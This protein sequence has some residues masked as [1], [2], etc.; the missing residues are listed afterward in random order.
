MIIEGVVLSIIVGYIRKGR[1]AN[2]EH[3]EVRG[4]Y[5]ILLSQMFQIVAIRLNGKVIQLDQQVFYIMH[6]MSYVFLFVPLFMNYKMLSM[7]LLG[8]GTVFNFIPVALNGG[9]MPVFLPEGVNAT[10]DLGHVLGNVQTK[11]YLLADII[12][13]LRPYPLPKVISIGDI[14]LLVGAFLF[15]QYGMEKKKGVVNLQISD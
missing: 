6:F 12:P 1:L 7:K 14:F 8:M 15:V 4:W 5:L 3:I 9:Q 13:L 10:F 11:A 2:F